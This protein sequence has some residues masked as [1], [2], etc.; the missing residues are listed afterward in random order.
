MKIDKHEKSDYD[1]ATIEAKWKTGDSINEIKA[2]A[3]INHNCPN[4]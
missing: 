2:K 4:K 1:E 3:I